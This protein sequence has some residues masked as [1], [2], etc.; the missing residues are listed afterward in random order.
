MGRVYIWDSRSCPSPSKVS[1]PTPRTRAPAPG[2][3]RLSPVRSRMRVPSRCPLSRVVCVTTCSCT[4]H[5]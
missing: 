2:S 1:P 3:N 4:L 5:R